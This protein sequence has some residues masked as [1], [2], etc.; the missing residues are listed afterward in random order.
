[1]ASTELPPPGKSLSRPF[2]VKVPDV[3]RNTSTELHLVAM[4]Y[5][6]RTAAFIYRYRW[7]PK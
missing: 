4:V 7:V 2:S 3:G 5:A 6:S 1:M